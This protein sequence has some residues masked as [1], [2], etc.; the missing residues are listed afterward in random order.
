MGLK[1]RL[2][3][4]LQDALRSHDERR[5]SVI[6]ISLAEI[7]H[8][9][10]AE[11]GDLDDARVVALLRKQAKQR[12]ETIEELRQ[13]ER[14]DALAEEEAKLDILEGYLPSLFSREQVVEEARRVIAQLGATGMGQMGQV[15]RS[16][17]S[18]LEG[19][20]DGRVVNE[21]VRELLSG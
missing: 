3:A 11:K 14:V 17:M 12:Q 8:A 15:M 19:R 5:K 2:Q 1:Q 9:E 13:T 4:D 6:R 21:V 16:L 10:V 20:A 7:A 18:E